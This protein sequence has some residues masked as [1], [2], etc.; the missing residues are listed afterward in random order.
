MIQNKDNVFVKGDKDSSADIMKK[1]DYATKLGTMI[2]DDI[3]KG[4]YVENADNTLKKLSLVHEF[5]YRNFHNYQCYKD[6]QPDRNQTAHLYGTA[7]T[8]TFETLED[9][10]VANLKFWPIIDQTGAF[11]YNAAKVRSDLKPLCKNEYSISDTQKFLSMLSSIQPL[12]G[13]K[14][15]ASHDVEWVI[16]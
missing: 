9:I 6:M 8:N 10:T 15:D 2:D 13:G 1:S 4:T 14:E 5:L 16:I 3:M 12:Q 7:Q 11:T